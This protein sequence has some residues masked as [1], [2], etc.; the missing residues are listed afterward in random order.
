MCLA[1]DGR[2][3]NGMK[4]GMQLDKEGVENGLIGQATV[5]ETRPAVF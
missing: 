2:A 1:G 4:W 5:T 3:R